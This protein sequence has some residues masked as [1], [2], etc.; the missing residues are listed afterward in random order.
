MDYFQITG[1]FGCRKELEIRRGEGVRV[2]QFLLII[3]RFSIFFIFF[4]LWSI[5]RMWVIIILHAYIIHLLSSTWHT[6]I[7]MGF[8]PGPFWSSIGWST[9]WSVPMCHI[10]I[11]IIILILNNP[12]ASSPPT[13]CTSPE[14]SMSVAFDIQSYI[15]YYL[16]DGDQDRRSLAS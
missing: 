10:I 6:W 2:V 16:A 12:G 8:G 15:Q 7:Y 14:V 3:Y 11:I 9:S 1:F 5:R 4:C 13:I